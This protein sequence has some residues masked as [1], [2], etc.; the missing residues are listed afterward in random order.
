MPVPLSDEPTRRKRAPRTLLAALVLL[1]ALAL[2]ATLAA[3]ATGGKAAAP[4]SVSGVVVTG[5]LIPVD[6]GS[7]VGWSPTQAE[8][9]VYR[10]G[11]DALVSTTH[12]DADGR[13][14]LKLAARKLP[15]LCPL[16]RHGLGAPVERNHRHSDGRWQGPGSA[17]VRHGRT[18]PGEPWSRLHGTGRRLRSQTT[19]GQGIEGAVSIGPVKPVSTPGQP[20]TKPYA[21]HLRIYRLDGTPAAAV[22]SDTRGSFSVGLPAGEYIVQPGAGGPLFPRANLF[23]IAIDKGQWRCVTIRYDSGIR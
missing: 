23:S 8:V 14:F 4:G 1:A 17:V 16:Q 7:P 20:D 18:L 11:T 19:L 9:L 2:I 10:S 21:T 3:I 13:F 15:P 6:P 5:P 12:S 22:A